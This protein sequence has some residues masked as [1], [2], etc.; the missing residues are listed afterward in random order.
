M[1][2]HNKGEFV[3]HIGVRLVPGV[4]KLLSFQEKQFEEALNHKLNQHLV[5]SG[6]I[7]IVKGEKEEKAASLSVLN[8]EKAIDLVKDS[9]SL[10]TIEGFLKEEEEGKKRKTVLGA[11]QEQIEDIKNPPE[12]KVVDKDE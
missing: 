2:I 7:V 9:F 3:R 12:D 4:N 10:E 6:E 1:L 5:D 11:I 8:A